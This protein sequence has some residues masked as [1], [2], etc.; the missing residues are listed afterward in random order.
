MQVGEWMVRNV[1]V[2]RY[3]EPLADA[4]ARLRAS[5]RK[6]M[7]VMRRGKLIG[8]LYADADLAGELRGARVGDAMEPPSVVVRAA[9]RVED[10]VRRMP[11]GIEVPVIDRGRLVGLTSAADLYACMRADDLTPWLE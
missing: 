7:P 10:A 1:A 8:V 2:A 9:E 5:G 11:D 3:D 4:Q 6:C